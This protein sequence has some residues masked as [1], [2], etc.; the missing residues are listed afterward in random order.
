MPKFERIP[1]YR[2]HESWG[3]AVVTL[4]GRRDFYL[5]P[6]GT[7]ASRDEYD[8]VIAEWLANGRQLIVSRKPRLML[9]SPVRSA[10]KTRERMTGPRKAVQLNLPSP[11]KGAS[12]N[13]HSQRTGALRRRSLGKSGYRTAKPQ[14]GPGAYPPPAGR[15]ARCP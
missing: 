15:R 10:P 5:G 12:S 6:H 8:R 4:S 1:S 13:P 11:E 14:E 2:L 3:R 7:P 9:C